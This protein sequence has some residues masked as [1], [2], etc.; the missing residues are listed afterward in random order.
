[1]QFGG[2]YRHE[3]F[4]YRKEPATDKVDFGA[5]ATALENPATGANYTATP[6]TGYADADQFLGAAEDYIVNLQPPYIHF[7]DMEF[8][9]YFQDNYHVA[10]NLTLNLGV[11]YEAHPAPWVKNGTMTA[12]T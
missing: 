5:Y 4:G 12:S 1:M 10:R 7:H 3:R 11:R 8:D 9:G 2:R 6:N